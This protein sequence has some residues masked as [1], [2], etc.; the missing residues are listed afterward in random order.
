MKITA[1]VTRLMG[2]NEGR[3]V[4]YSKDWD[5]AMPASALAAAAQ[6]RSARTW[7]S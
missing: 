3:A 4:R 2:G 1:T 5:N 6:C 7:A